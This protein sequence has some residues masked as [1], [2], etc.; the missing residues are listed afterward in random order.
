M[1]TAPVS[2]AM[3]LAGHSVGSRYPETAPQT[4]SATYVQTHMG[5]GSAWI[6]TGGQFSQ[7]ALNSNNPVDG[8][9]DGLFTLENTNQRG[10]LRATRPERNK[11][12]RFSPLG[13]LER[14]GF[15]CGVSNR[16]CR[17]VGIACDS[18]LGVKLQPVPPEH[19]WAG[20]LSTDANHAAGWHNARGATPSVTPQSLALCRA[21]QRNYFFSSVPVL[22]SSCRS[23]RCL[24]RS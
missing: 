17:S 22:R 12:L 15:E 19:P 20:L 18:H 8:H 7:R 23:L 4:P 24:R 3:A 10:K 13:R 1:H 6:S 2:I 5:R 21:E 11:F 9:A 16:N 14:F